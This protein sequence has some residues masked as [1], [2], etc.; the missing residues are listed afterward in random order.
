MNKTLTC[1]VCPIGCSLTIDEAGRVTGNHCR[2][3][4]EFAKT[5]TKNPTR[6]VTTTI[7]IE[8]AIH[9]RLPV[10]SSRPVPKS[11]V[12][13]FVH[14]VQRLKVSAP[15][16]CGDILLTNVLGLGIDLIASRSFDVRQ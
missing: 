11:K 12:M 13:D 15:I 4:E 10:V 16:N 3:G 8:G 7:G 1:I 6:V 14:E 5:E 2:R 9:R